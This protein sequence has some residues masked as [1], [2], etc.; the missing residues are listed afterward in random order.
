MQYRN[1][2]Y[3]GRWYV[4]EECF[5]KA[6]K[7]KGEKRGL[8][9]YY[10][11]KGHILTVDDIEEIGDYANDYDDGTQKRKFKPYGKGD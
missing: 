2:K 5:M 1:V 6:R 9:T 4:A 3:N 10:M 7:V 8:I 11:L